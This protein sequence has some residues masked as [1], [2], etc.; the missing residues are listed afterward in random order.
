MLFGMPCTMLTSG[1]TFACTN[2][3]F[4]NSSNDNTRP[5]TLRTFPFGGGD[6]DAGVVDVVCESVFVSVVVCVCWVSVLAVGVVSEFGTEFGVGAVAGEDWIVGADMVEA[7]FKGLTGE[8]GLVGLLIDFLQVSDV[9]TQGCHV[10]LPYGSG[11]V[12]ERVWVMLPV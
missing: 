5:T 4:T 2:P 3:G 6:W 8:A 9:V 7:G 11:H 12:E 1:N 10:G